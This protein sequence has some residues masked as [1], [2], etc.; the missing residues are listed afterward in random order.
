[1]KTNHPQ[2][3]RRHIRPQDAIGIAQLAAH[4]TTE[5]MTVTE[6]LHLSILHATGIRA[7]GAFGW[8][9]RSTQLMYAGLK[10]T[11]KATEYLLRPLAKRLNRDAGDI[12]QQ[13]RQT[14]AVINGV[15]GDQLA[16]NHNPLVTSF[17]LFTPV[18][19]SALDT[20]HRI[21]FLHG[22]C[23]DETAWQL[24]ELQQPLQNAG[25]VVTFVRYNSGLPIADNA[26][27]LVEAMA[28][29]YELGVTFSLVGHSMG[30]LIA[31][32]AMHE[33]A[34]Q[35]REFLPAL[36]KIICV[37]SPHLGAP[38]AKLGNWLE[39]QLH[40]NSFTQPF[41]FLTRL[42]SAGIKDLQHGFYAD[43]VFP[44]TQFYCLAGELPSKYNK[45]KNQL[46]DGL[47]TERSALGL[48]YAEKHIIENTSHLGLLTDSRAVTKVSQW[49]HT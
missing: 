14:L 25:Y 33:A 45:V 3:W 43:H 24:P 21:L 49:L 2:R 22:L 17:E 18:T 47:V 23:M 1:M 19:A 15:M 11:P 29:L 32:L 38:M 12:S 40:R 48:P 39:Q 10:I 28:E 20:K 4:A 42:R 31:H 34:R 46:G 13:R 7:D 27:H 6:H 41:T 44:N 16:A 37:G 5:V 8:L 26:A 9:H 35:H 30:G 36:R